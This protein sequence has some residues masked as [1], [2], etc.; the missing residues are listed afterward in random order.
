MFDGNGK[1]IDNIHIYYIDEMSVGGTGLF[2]C[3]G[4]G[5]IIQNLG[6]GEKSTIEGMDQTGALV[7][8]MKGGLVQYCYNE[9][10]IDMKSGMI[11]GGLVG[12]GEN[13]K[14]ANCYNRGMVT[15]TT[16]A[17]GI[18][19]FADKDFIVENCYNN[20]MIYSTGFTPA[21][22]IG[23]LCSGRISNCYNAGLFV[24][25]DTPMGVVGDIDAGVIIE[26][27]YFLEADGV[28]NE[29]AGVT[30]KTND[31]MLSVDFLNVLNGTQSPAPWV[32]DVNTVNE[33]L[34]ILAWQISGTTGMQ[35]TQQELDCE[36]FV[37]NQAVYVTFE[38]SESGEVIVMDMTGRTIIDKTIQ[39]GDSVIILDK[40][41]Y[42]V[43]VKADGQ[44]HITKI[45]IK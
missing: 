3:I 31:E 12:G 6:I 37:E 22:V 17:A 9:G 14:I 39:S 19:G 45:A 28:E 36:L 7:G 33:G 24:I 34:P 32:A 5:A 38:S 43:M 25:D 16:Y 35:A 20:G 27:C 42:I 15:G 21:G 41:I 13:G 2:G 10:T 4:K 18:I 40:G 8:Y 23:Y 26:N 44:Q 29:H 11:S 1:N 30:S